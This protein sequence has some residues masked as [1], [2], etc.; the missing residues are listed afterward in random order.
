MADASEEADGNPSTE[1]P[2]ENKTWD[3]L[4]V[5]N[6]DEYFGITNSQKESRPK[7]G[8]PWT[9]VRT[10]VT[11]MADLKQSIDDIIAHTNRLY[12]NHRARGISRKP[13]PMEWHRHLV[14]E[15]NHDRVFKNHRNEAELELEEDEAKPVA[16]LNQAQQRAIHSRRGGQPPPFGA[17]VCIAHLNLNLHRKSKFYALA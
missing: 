17:P 6:P 14:N 11:L 7:I 4:F 13:A 1:D 9:V 8:D 2:E 16:H 12:V 5:N 3:E 10:S 15:P